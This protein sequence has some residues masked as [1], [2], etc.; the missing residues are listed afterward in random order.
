MLDPTLLLT[1]EEWNKEIKECPKEKEKYILAYVVEDNE[2]YRKI[3]NY[4][5]EKTGLKVIHFEKKDNYKNVL[6]MLIQRD[7]WNL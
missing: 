1:K 6:K 2:E 7:Q 5:S 3:V 4:L